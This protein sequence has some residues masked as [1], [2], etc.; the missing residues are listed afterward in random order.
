M[1]VWMGLLVVLVPL[2]ASAQI[3]FERTYGGSGWDEGRSVCQMSDGGYVLVGC[4]E[5]FGAG[6]GDVYVVRTDHFGDTL[7]TRT[8]GGPSFD[9]GRSVAQTGD[10]GCIIAGET[11]SFGAQEY[12]FYVI[13]IDALGDTLWTGLYGGLY[14]DLAHSVARTSDGGYII[15]GE[16][17]SFGAGSADVYL[18]KIDAMGGTTWT[19]SYGGP[20]F[21]RAHVIRQTSDGGYIVVGQTASFGAGGH[22]VYLVR[23]D[24]LGDSLWAYAYGG[25]QYEVGYSVV[26]TD[27]GGYLVVGYTYSFGMGS[28]DIYLVKTDSVGGTVWTRTYGFIQNDHGYSIAKIADGGY[29]IAGQWHLFGADEVDLCLLRTDS[30]GDTLWMRTYGDTLE[31][32]GYSVLQTSDGGYVVAG[33]TG[34]AFDQGNGDLYVVKTDADGLVGVNHAPDLVDQADTTVAENQYLTFT[35]E[36]TDP[37]LD[38]IA[39]SCIDLPSGATLDEATG[40]FEWT[41][42]YTQSGLYTVTFIATDFG[43]PALAD[44]EKTAITVT[45]VVRVAGDEGELEAPAQYLAQN[46]SNPFCTSTAISYSLRKAGPVTV[47]VYDIRGALVREL[48][49]ETVAAGV[50][51]VIWDGRDG[52]GSKVGSGIYFCRLAAGEFS[53]TRRMVL[54]R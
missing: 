35:L 22:D 29:V 32:V 3:S 34:P 53:E 21:E 51:R 4:T 39:F 12:D 41:P 27:D 19:R 30:Q 42:T 2:T 7:W 8:Y 33:Y 18:A 13:R 47:S 28:S 46:R 49:N 50:H 6:S 1:R 38:S 52:R 45:D 44:T 31:D 15:A 14:Y 36:A 25:P 43:E 9:R 5:S 24:A 23:T 20:E 26:E 10:G 54:L 48:V 17:N 11:S 16:T 37:E 40:L